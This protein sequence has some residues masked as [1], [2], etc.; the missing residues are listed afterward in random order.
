[1]SWSISG[2]EIMAKMQSEKFSN[3]LYSS[4]DELFNSV[5]TKKKFDKIE[6][7]MILSAAEVNKKVAKSKI[8]AV[9]KSS[10]SIYR[11]CRY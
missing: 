11:T 6:E 2:A 5:L 4:F 1:M 7:I 10:T 9:H 3:R 8:Y